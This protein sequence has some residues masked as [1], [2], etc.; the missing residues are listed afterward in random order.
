MVMVAQ[1][2]EYTKK[3]LMVYFKR[4]KSSSIKK[5]NS[6][7]CNF[8]KMSLSLLLSVNHS[9]LCVTLRSWRLVSFWVTFQLPLLTVSVPGPA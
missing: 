9:L 3:Y 7:S 6:G 5:K 4:A 8:A 1:L 2:C